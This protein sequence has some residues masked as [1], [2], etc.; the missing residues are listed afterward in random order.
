VLAEHRERSGE[1]MKQGKPVNKTAAAVI[2]AI[3][4]LLATLGVIYAVRIL[5]NYK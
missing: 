3:W 2:I 1:M 5:R 4:L